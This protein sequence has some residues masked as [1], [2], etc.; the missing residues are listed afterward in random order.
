SDAVPRF[1]VNALQENAV[2]PLGQPELDLPEA[3]DGADLKFTAEV[4]VKPEI[5]LP[6]YHGIEVSVEDA[7]VS[8]EHVEERLESLRER[9]GTLQP[10]GDRPAAEGDHVT[11]DLSG[12]KD[13]EPVEELQ[14]T[15][16]SY[17]VGS[18]NLLDGLDE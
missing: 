5:T 2:E 17:R 6:E 14:A 9:F 10:A 13:G 12:S 3:V 8:A 16:L 7:T 15:G 1:Y 11:I 18:G 4:D